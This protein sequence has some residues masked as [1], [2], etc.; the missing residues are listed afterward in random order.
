MSLTPSKRRAN[1]LLDRIL[2]EEEASLAD[3]AEALM[4]SPDSVMTQAIR[5]GRRAQHGARPAG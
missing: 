4:V 2:S 3:V 5:R 1:D